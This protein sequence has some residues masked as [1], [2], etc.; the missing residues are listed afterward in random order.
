MK[1][2]YEECTMEMVMLDAVR[3][4]SVRARNN[5]HLI[6]HDLAT[7]DPAGRLTVCARMAHEAVK[8][9]VTETKT[10]KMS[11]DPGVRSSCRGVRR[12][13]DLTVLLTGF[14]AGVT[15]LTGEG[16]STRLWR[17]DRGLRAR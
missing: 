13:P 8:T 3:A 16:V 4:R 6:V 15:T 17:E 10:L 11:T 12:A 1:K 5:Q 14:A 7:M 2:D 9:D